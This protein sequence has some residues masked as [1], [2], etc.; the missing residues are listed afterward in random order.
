VTARVKTEYTN[1]IDEAVKNIEPGT[2]TGS[3]DMKIAT[4]DD[5]TEMLG[6]IFPEESEE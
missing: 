2:G 6:E 1:A 5:V 3:C 4:E